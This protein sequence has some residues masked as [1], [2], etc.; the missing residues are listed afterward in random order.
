M[1]LSRAGRRRDARFL[2]EL[3]AVG[4]FLHF[5]RG[6]ASNSVFHS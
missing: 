5:E 3:L 1:A 4:A 6:D 2:E